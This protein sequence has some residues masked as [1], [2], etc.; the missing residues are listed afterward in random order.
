M[1]R[2]LLDDLFRFQYAQRAAAGVKRGGQTVAY[3]VTVTMIVNLQFVI[4]KD[5]LS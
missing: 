5:L 2:D 3:S 1:S 4:L